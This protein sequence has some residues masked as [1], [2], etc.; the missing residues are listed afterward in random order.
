M[1]TTD[2]PTDRTERRD[3]LMERLFAANIAAFE[4]L[5]V[6]LGV[7]LGLYEALDRGGAATP[8]ELADRAGIHPRYARE[9]LEQQA[10]A[11]ILEVDDPAR[12]PHRRSFHLP[13]AHRPVL[14]E[15]DHPAYLAPLAT[16]LA[17]ITRVLPDRLPEAYRNGAG[18]PFADYGAETRE[19][20]GRLN[21]VMFVNDLAGWLAALPDVHARLKADPPARVADI[22]CGTG[23]STINLARAYP[24]VRVEGYDLDAASVE[25]ARTNAR[26]TGVGDRVAFH[27][28]DAADLD[29]EPGYDLACLFEGL[30][31]MADPVGALA[32]VRRILAEGGCLLLADERVA[33]TF[34][35]PADE[36][37]RFLYGWSVLHCVPASLAER[38]A[39]P[40]DVA[41]TCLRPATVRAWAGQARFS[42]VEVLDIENDFWRFYRLDP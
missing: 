13:V 37:E 14:L 9:W 35:P 16:G 33:E 15:A 38:P 7:Q 39:D 26:S 5:S 36:V 1:T 4:L 3:A 22:A 17:G 29:A 21:R 2:V 11:G 40:D 30:H 31:D 41:G 28:G 34:D 18:I 20:I 42:S 23:W 8:D 12:E 24:K 19:G 10:A 32:A 25:A 6:H 27:A